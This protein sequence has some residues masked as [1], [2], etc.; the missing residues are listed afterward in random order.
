VRTL[1]GGERQRVALATAWW[2]GAPLLLLDE[3]TA[4]LD[5]SHQELLVQRLLE[6]S[7]SVV[8][9]L[10]DLNLA[11][12]VATHAVLLDGRGG[13]ALGTRDAVLTPERLGHAFA[14]PIAWVEVC[15][16]RRLWVGPT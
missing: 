15:G 12:R 13:V 16:Q 2:Q 9:S 1:S 10:H 7:G 4:H 3:P 11:W 6:H 5:L 8:A 14:V